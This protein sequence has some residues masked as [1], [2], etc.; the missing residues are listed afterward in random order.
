MISPGIILLNIL[1]VKIIQERGIPNNQPG[2]N[3]MIIDQP[4][5]YVKVTGSMIIHHYLYKHLDEPIPTTIP[6]NQYN[7]YNP[8]I[9][10]P[11]PIRIPE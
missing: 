8:I 9:C 10:K 1:R 4:F 3:G 7:L 2:F 6:I 5:S 11:I